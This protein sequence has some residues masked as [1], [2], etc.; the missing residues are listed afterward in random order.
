MET[1]PAVPKEWEMP[2]QEFKEMIGKTILYRKTRPIA[3]ELGIPSF[4][5]NIVNYTVSLLAEMTA[6]RIDLLKIWEQQDISDPMKN[7]ITELLPKVGKMITASAGNRNPTEWF[8]SELCWKH[9]RDAANSWTIPENVK[10]DLTT[11]GNI[12]HTVSHTTENNIAKCLGV[13]AETW[14]KIQL[15]GNQSSKLLN[16]Q[17]GIAN[18]LAGYAA[19]GWKKKPSEKQAKR[20]VEILKLA[21]E[22]FAATQE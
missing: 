15:W 3:L 2:A 8:K 6:R 10:A 13:N 21:E 5:V 19:A 4:R 9:L 22:L 20:G 7:W 12:G 16:W 14:F 11:V 17:C 18:T 1:V